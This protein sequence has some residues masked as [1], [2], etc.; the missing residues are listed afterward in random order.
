MQVDIRVGLG[1]S[2]SVLCIRWGRVS[3]DW[4]LYA[5]FDFWS[6]GGRAKSTEMCVV[7]ALFCRSLGLVYVCCNVK[8]VE[9]EALNRWNFLYHDI[10]CN[11][12]MISR[13]RRRWSGFTTS[14]S[15]M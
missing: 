13:Y 15:T 11:S 14:L 3:Q 10:V 4:G 7:L 6:H 2:C 8:I 12:V 9:L 1:Q 5:V